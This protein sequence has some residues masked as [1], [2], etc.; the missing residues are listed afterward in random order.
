MGAVVILRSLFFFQLFLF[1][2][3]ATTDFFFFFFF[4]KFPGQGSNPSLS[5]SNARSFN[6][7]SRAQDRTQAS[8]AARAAAGG[9]LTQCAAVGTAD[10]FAALSSGCVSGGTAPAVRTRPCPCAQQGGMGSLG[11]S[12]PG[13]AAPEVVLSHPKLEEEGPNGPPLR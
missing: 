7:L 6:S 13:H 9:F 4:C 3:G 11:A 12:F 1:V 2:P 5:C 8:S 10:F